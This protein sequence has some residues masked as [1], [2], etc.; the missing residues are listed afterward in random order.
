[1]SLKKAIVAT[2]VGAIPDMLAENS[3]VIIKPRDIDSIVSEFTKLVLNKEERKVLGIN[4]YNRVKKYYDIE[5]T[6]EK[7][8]EIWRKLTT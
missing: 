6:Y 2:N 4:A 8:K 1:M 3:G 5:I 7:Y